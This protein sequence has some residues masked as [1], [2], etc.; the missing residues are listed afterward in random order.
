M[1][2]CL[3]YHRK[4]KYNN[5]KKNHHHPKPTQPERDCCL[6]SSKIKLIPSEELSGVD[7]SDY[8]SMK[9]KIANYFLPITKLWWREGLVL[10]RTSCEWTQDILQQMNIAL[11]AMPQ[12]AQRCKDLREASPSHQQCHHTAKSHSRFRLLSSLLFVPF[13]NREG[14]EKQVWT[15][16]AMPE[17]IDF[18]I[19]NF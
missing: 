17:K 14:L 16:Q 11:T 10:L 7:F 8:C 5:N 19:T 6:L 3:N 4:K 1:K 2:S 13:L 12:P 15:K 9:K 18:S